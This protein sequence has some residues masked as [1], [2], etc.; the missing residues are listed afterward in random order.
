MNTFIPRSRSSRSRAPEER[1]G[2]RRSSPRPTSRASSSPVLEQA[3]RR[4][5]APSSPVRAIV[6]GPSNPRARHKLQRGGLPPNLASAIRQS[7]AP[8]LSVSRG[9]ALRRRQRQSNAAS[10][11]RPPR[12]RATTAATTDDARRMSWRLLVTRR[13]SPPAMLG[14]HRAGATGRSQDDRPKHGRRKLPA[15]WAGRP[16]RGGATPAAGAPDKADADACPSRSKAMV[17]D[18]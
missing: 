16:H 8:T 18:P 11:G 17:V 1:V 3:H 9:R 15:L 7:G 10:R 6:A 4:A 2:T 14:E 13:A 5:P 12:A